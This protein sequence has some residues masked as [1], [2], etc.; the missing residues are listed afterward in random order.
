MATA[1]KKTK[2]KAVGEGKVKQTSVPTGG[3][4]IFV[5]ELIQDQFMVRVQ[6]IGMKTF[7][8]CQM[9]QKAINQLEDKHDGKK[10]KASDR[11]AKDQYK[12]FKDCG[13]W[14]HDNK[15]GKIT[16]LCATAIMVKRATVDA[17]RHIDEKALTLVATRSWFFVYGADQR[18][19]ELVPLTSEGPVPEALK[20]KMDYRFT[21]ELDDGS[22]WVN[23]TTDVDGFKNRI[24]EMKYLNSIGISMRQ[25]AVSPNMGGKDLRYRPVVHNWSAEFMVSFNS[26]VISAQALINL[27]SCGGFHNGIGEWR[28]SSPKASGMWGQFEVV[29]D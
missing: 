24:Q 2:T 8:C 11:E 4:Q 18:N 25:D 23:K 26:R 20:T 3:E 19:P 16:N 27:I 17:V 6:S 1:T 29:T 28:P 7:G 22:Q 9:T 5:P 15:T 13:Y 21:G 14:M 12:E 10:I